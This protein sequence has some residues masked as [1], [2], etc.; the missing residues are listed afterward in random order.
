MS[1]VLGSLSIGKS[2]I[3]TP[4][5]QRGR[6]ENPITLRLTSKLVESGRTR[7]ARTAV[8][9]KRMSRRPLAEETR[10]IYLVRE[11]PR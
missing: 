3:R 1:S 11:R 5:S 7:G 2:P 6:I 9:R 10:I 4:G 8:S